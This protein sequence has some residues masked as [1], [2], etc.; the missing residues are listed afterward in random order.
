MAGLELHVYDFDGT[1]FG[2]PL[3]PDGW[4]KGMGTWFES[5]G[6]LLPPCVPEHPGSEWW[7]SNVV[8][9]A[10]QS[11]ANPNVLAI[12]MT[13][14]TNRVG[15]RYR[16]AELLD[17]AGLDFD[18]VYLKEGF[19]ST[20]DFKAHMLGK[21]LRRFPDISLVKMWDDRH[22]HFPIF[23]E[24]VKNMGVSIETYPVD[25]FSNP[26]ECD[27]EEM[28]EA[29]GRKDYVNVY[30]TAAQA[31][32]GQTRR[33][34]EPY[35]SHPSSVRNIVRRYYP[36]D[37]VAQLAALLHDT[38]E[39]APRIGTVKSL[40]EMEEKI[41]GAIGD[42]GVAYEVLETVRHV[43]HESND[44]TSYI[45]GLV[46][47]PRAL[48]VKLSDMEHNL[49]TASPRQRDKYGAAIMVIANITDGAPP[50]G[51]S[52]RHWKKILKMIKPAELKEVRDL[53][54]R[55]LLEST[56][57]PTRVKMEMPMPDDL[58]PLHQR[59]KSS[60]YKLYIVGG[61]VRDLI[62]G[63]EPKDYDLATDATPDKVMLI[64]RRHGN[65]K[66]DLTGKDFGVV[67]AWTPAGNE[68]EIATFR[69]DV[70][71]GR[72]PD[73]VK[74]TTIEDD[75]N[76][77]DLTV[78][79]L[80][81]DLDTGEVVDY[82]GGIEDVET[83]TIRAVGDPKQRFN[84]DRLRILRA[85]RFA[86][87]MGGDIDGKTKDII[88]S[89]PRLDLVS[90]DRIQDEL[91]KGIKQAKSIP[92]FIELL[93]ELNLMDQVFPGLTVSPS[94]SNHRDY[95]I[96]IALLL[97]GNESKDI[98]TVLKNMRY[99]NDDI[100]EITFLIEL[101]KITGDTAPAL[102]KD[103]QKR[104]R[105]DPNRII[106]FA[107]E[108]G[109]DIKPFMKYLK[110]PPA[111]NP[112][113]LMAQGI[114]GPQLGV[115]LAKKEK[116]AYESLFEGIRQFVRGVLSES[117]GDSEHIFMNDLDPTMPVIILYPNSPKYEFFKDYFK[118]TH[119]FNWLEKNVMFVDGHAVEQGWFTEDHLL[120]MQAH[121]YGHKVAG[122]IEKQQVDHRDPVLEREADWVGYNILKNRGYDSAAGLHET[123][124]EIRYGVKPDAVA[125][126][127]VHLMDVIQ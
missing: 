72:R 102:K 90:E 29:L 118:N 58:M 112:R 65:I 31:H 100:K 95:V 63:K 121:E 125:G 50:T 1:L 5:P 4:P 68:Y 93:M 37:R 9:S 126:E 89:D 54:K 91:K 32:R 28:N 69:E 35:F 82:V 104:V 46:S 79:A 13:G 39:D 119:A 83:A 26:A 116:E 113:D 10:K 12:M 77:R 117:V 73:A 76:R 47:K 8:A 34:G 97:M 42:K 38:L 110:M 115:A 86:A 59:F 124:F 51:I 55:V 92:H 22:N 15:L 71:E 66:M 24:T 103:Q 106:G 108:L 17:S 98:T 49:Q 41:L 6:S 14:R 40:E 25:H 85:V 127:M 81:Y 19:T 94:G 78:N 84:E 80:F 33:D 3:P 21:I 60:G 105:M 67:R 75:V 53:I 64:L 16:I 88:K 52:A 70:G 45:M 62:L 44:Y 2:S 11:I 107:N 61:A 99:S 43:T 74:F 48:R 123:E 18:A 120:V 20:P 23:S 36:N 101:S 87:R 56:S 30:R 7:N 27:V 109:F 114:K 111:A 57:R 96:Q 122:H